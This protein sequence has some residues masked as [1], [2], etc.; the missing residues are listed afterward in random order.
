MAA[1]LQVSPLAGQTAL[2][3]LPIMP[4]PGSNTPPG[5]PGESAQSIPPRM[6][7]PPGQMGMQQPPISPGI[8][9]VGTLSLSGRRTGRNGFCHHKIASTRNQK[10]SMYSG[11][12]GA[13]AAVSNCADCEIGMAINCNRVARSIEL[14]VPWAAVESGQENTPTIF[15]ICIDGQSVQYHGITELQ[16][17]IGYLPKMKIWPG[18]EIL[19]KLSSGT[20]AD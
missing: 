10:W 5:L 2:Q 11:N 16:G 19:E 13:I 14:F 4:L 1:P 20:Y 17:A 12:D 18:H 3:P 15:N 8:A 7:L 9:G 6:A